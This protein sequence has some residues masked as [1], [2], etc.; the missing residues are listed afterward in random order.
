MNQLQRTAPHPGVRRRRLQ[1]GVIGQQFRWPGD[2]TPVG[3]HATGLYGGAG[4]GAAVE[5]APGNQKDVGARRQV[6]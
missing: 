6:A 3:E 1:R 2:P 4:P 5:Q